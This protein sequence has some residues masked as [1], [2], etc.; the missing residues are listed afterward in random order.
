MG[1]DRNFKGGHIEVDQ[2]VLAF[3]RGV[4]FPMGLSGNPE[5]GVVDDADEFT[6]GLKVARCISEKGDRRLSMF[7]GSKQANGMGK[8]RRFQIQGFG[9]VGDRNWQLGRVGFFFGAGDEGAERR[10]PLP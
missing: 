10:R 2:S 1:L 5:A 3:F 7:K 8:R 9:E 4:N 6:A